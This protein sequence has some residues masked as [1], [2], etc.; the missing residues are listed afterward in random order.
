MNPV[1]LLLL[2]GAAHAQDTTTETTTETT[3]ETTADTTADT[4]TEAATPDEAAAPAEAAAPTEAAAPAEAATPTVEDTETVEE[5]RAAS[6]SAFTTTGEARL[7]GSSYPDTAVD[8]VGGTTGQGLVLD[9]RLRAGLDWKRERFSLGGEVQVLNGQIAGDTWDIP[10]TEDLRHREALSATTDGLFQLRRAAVEGRIGKVGLQAGL[11]GSHWGL[12]MLAN[13]GNH[14]PV[15]GRTDFGDRVL[16]VRVA[17]RPFHGGRTPLTLLAAGDRVIEDGSARWNPLTGGQAA[18]QGLAAALW[19]DKQTFGIYGVYRDQTEADGER[20][21]RVSVLDVYADAPIAL[22]DWTLRLAGEAAGITGHTSVTQTYNSRDGLAIRQAGVTA[23]A[24]LKPPSPKWSALLRAGWASGDGQADD[25]TLHDFAFS[26]DFDV[27]M[28]TFDEVQG[29]IDAA[30]YAQLQDPAN[31]GGAP[32]GSDGL[33]AEGAFRHAAF[34]QPSVHLLPLAWLGL[35]AGA[36]LSWNTGPVAEPYQSY[37][38]GG[39]PSNQLGQPTSGYALGTE[40]DWALT[41]GDT[42]VKVGQGSLKPALLIQGGHLLASDNLGGGTLS[43]LTAT[44]RV[45]W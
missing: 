33:V 23:L 39:V 3:A 6:T 32:E 37:R 4:T 17:T 43:V 22:S 45:R 1:L 40:L 30:T 13:D 36:T 8:A 19:Q 14:D 26:R 41:V 9:S 28:V 16:R 27:G 5:A 21:T 34:V 38:N 20:K 11:V 44:G 31:G 35:R 2:A 29:A 15:F 7:I 10:G 25:G 18:W 42:A 12:G 24:E